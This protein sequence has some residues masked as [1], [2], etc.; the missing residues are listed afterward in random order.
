LGYL[1]WDFRDTEGEEARP[2]ETETGDIARPPPSVGR[3]RRAPSCGEVPA[4][5]RMVYVR[6]PGKG[7]SNSHGA[8]PVY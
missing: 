7:N 4:P 2:R 6:L 8:R 3:S 5:G 1:E